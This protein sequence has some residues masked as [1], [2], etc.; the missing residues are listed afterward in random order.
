MNE[1]ITRLLIILIGGG[2]IAI[3]AILLAV[4]L[5]FIHNAILRLMNVDKND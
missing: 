3:G 4:I 1:F 2:L 5:S